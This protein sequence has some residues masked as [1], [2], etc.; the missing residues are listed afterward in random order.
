MRNL[1]LILTMLAIQNFI[2]GQNTYYS[3]SDG[4]WVNPA[5]WSLT[6]TG[7]G[8]AG[9]PTASDNIVIRDSIAHYPASGYIHYG[10]ILI[11][12]KSDYRVFL[13]SGDAYI[14]GGS[15]LDIYGKMRVY[16]DLIHQQAGSQGSGLII[17]NTWAKLHAGDD[18]ILNAFGSLIIDNPECGKVETCDDIYFVGSGGG[19]CGTGQLIIPD[20]I[21]VWDDAGVEITPIPAA[22]VAAANQVC[23]GFPIYAT[24]TDCS[25]NLPMLI[26]TNNT[27]P[28]EFLDFQANAAQ[29][30]INISWVTGNELNNDFFILERSIN[31]ETFI[32][33]TRIDGAGNSDIPLEYRFLDQEILRGIVQYRLKQTDFDGTAS[34]SSVVEIHIE[35]RTAAFSVFPNPYNGPQLHLEIVDV[36]E[37]TPLRI[38]IRDIQ[39]RIIYQGKTLALSTDPMIHHVNIQPKPGYYIVALITPNKTQ[40]AKLIVR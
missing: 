38:E 7:S 15:L 23:S 26:G 39:G 30:G 21:R 40:T 14:F 33:L 27:F 34:Y 4:D 11:Q 2:W 36:P 8:P 9:P 16:G 35:P 31:G 17:V 37:N 28:V 32:P 5:N 1:I 25:L 22:L 29:E 24:E 20:Q 10:D 12:K 6:E 3:V 19:V 18:I 13:N